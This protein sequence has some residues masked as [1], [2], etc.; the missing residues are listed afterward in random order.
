MSI[1]PTALTLKLRSGS[2]RAHVFGREGASLTLCVHGLSANSRSFDYLGEALASDARRLVALDLRGRGWSD[3]TG[4]GTYGWASHARDVL[5]LATALGAE[6]FD[7]VGHSM[8]AFVG[9]ELARRA[10]ARVSRMV[11]IDAVGTPE[12][13]ALPPILAAVKRLG[14]VHENA[15]AYVATV[16]RL[17]TVDP[18]S[19]YWE[20]H[21]RYDLVEA[22]G[23]V[24]ARTD[25][26][27]VLED[28]AYA[29][30]Q[31]PRA[32]WA[33]M[34]FRCLL[35]RSA[36]PLGAG[37]VVSERDRDLFVARA[38]RASA[39]DV[40]ANHYGVMTHADTAAAIGRFLQ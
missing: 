36:R 5:E 1:E 15:D 22:R 7:Y 19:A 37:F 16:Q 33:A 32:M 13:A 25:A 31:T 11:L 12:P 14:T 28:I 30:T 34:A 18:W 38:P 4:A 40:D 9:M 39:V 23:G 26:G 3:I 17:G 2:V 8:G 6:R 20:R 24:R 29:S 27:A 10:A 21:Y 35:V